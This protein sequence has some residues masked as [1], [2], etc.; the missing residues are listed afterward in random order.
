MSLNKSQF[1]AT[2]PLGLRGE[3]GEQ[4]VWETIKSAFINR[5]CLGY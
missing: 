2:E 1:I 3:K 4:L 5:D